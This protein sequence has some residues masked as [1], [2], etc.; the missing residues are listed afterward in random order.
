M[1]LRILC[2]PV[3]PLQEPCKFLAQRVL[4][5][6]KNDEV[7]TAHRFIRYIV[8]KM[9]VNYSPDSV[10]RLQNT[11]EFSLCWYFNALLC[12]DAA[13]SLCTR[14]NWFN[15]KNSSVN[16]MVG[17]SQLYRWGN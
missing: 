4:M 5:N 10:I 6:W 8:Y 1:I 12:T 17:F 15:P 3:F 2:F 14:M 13:L 9:K 11:V 16:W 7:F